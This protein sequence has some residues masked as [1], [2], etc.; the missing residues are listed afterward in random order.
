MKLVMG[1]VDVAYSDAN[2]GG[3]STTGEVAQILE[4][5]YHVME[6]FLV[7]RE[8]KIA[9]WL[10][11][12]LADEIADVVS[13]KPPSRD[14]FK[15]ATQQIEA[16]FRAFLD[17]N[18]MAH[19]VAGL[20]E[21]ESAAFDWSRTFNSAA[22]RGVSHR[23]KDV[24]NRALKGGKLLSAAIAGK[25]GRRVKIKPRGPRPAFIDTGLYQ[26]SFT[27]WIEAPPKEV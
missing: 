3:A 23:F 25:L 17:A 2:S 8:E 1:V 27:A 19:L 14:P 6:T 18:E 24:N 21:G 7:T 26:A 10:A 15:G 12:G 22:N 5:K 20:S 4:D 16:E 13:G 11:D 9:E